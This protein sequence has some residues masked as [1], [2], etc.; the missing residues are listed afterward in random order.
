V[1]VYSDRQQA[2]IRTAFVLCGNE[3]YRRDAG[4]VSAGLSG[5]L[6]V[7]V[8]DAPVVV[9]NITM[10]RTA[11]AIALAEAGRPVPAISGCPTY[12]HRVRVD[13]TG[14]RYLGIRVMMGQHVA[15]VTGGKRVDRRKEVCSSGRR[16]AVLGKPSPATQW[17]MWAD[18]RPGAYWYGPMRRQTDWDTGQVA[19]WSYGEQSAAWATGTGL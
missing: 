12:C 18:G 7:S 15:R 19:D 11:T 3:H 14:Q 5:E 8:W 2:Q 4:R 17:P 1:A 16:G 9:T 13:G 6:C 10:M